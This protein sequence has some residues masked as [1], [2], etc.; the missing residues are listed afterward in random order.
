[1]QLELF[2]IDPPM[3]EIDPNDRTRLTVCPDCG[4]T[5]PLIF[6]NHSWTAFEGWCG[7]RLFLTQRARG[8]VSKTD[9]IPEWVWA[10]MEW[11]KSH[12]YT[13]ADR[14]GELPDIP[15]PVRLVND[16]SIF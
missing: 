4:D 15:F 13:L 6:I 11:L 1:M 3:R 9:E 16:Y 2:T 7:K 5:D 10:D 12:G 14:W 8:W